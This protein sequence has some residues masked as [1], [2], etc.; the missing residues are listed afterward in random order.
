M[1]LGI[2]GISVAGILI[3]AIFLASKL[4]DN[5]RYLNEKSLEWNKLVKTK[6]LKALST[7]KKMSIDKQL[8]KHLEWDMPHSTKQLLKNYLDAGELS[9]IIIL[10][11]NCDILIS[12]GVRK[13]N[14][15]PCQSSYDFD[16]IDP[17]KSYA[18]KENLWLIQASMN[19]NSNNQQ[20]IIIGSTILDIN[21]QYPTLSS[22]A[23]FQDKSIVPYLKNNVARKVDQGLVLH[24]AKILSILIF[25][26]IA[27]ISLNEMILSRKNGLIL[28]SLFKLLNKDQGNFNEIET[29]VN[30][31]LKES[32][33]ISS[34]N[35]ALKVKLKKLD[36]DHVNQSKKVDRLAFYEIFLEAQTQTRSAL[37]K[38]IQQAMIS[39]SLSKNIYRD[40]K[41]ESFLASLQLSL[42]SL[43]LSLALDE[44]PILQSQSLTKLLHQNVEFENKLTEEVNFPTDTDKTLIS[45]AFFFLYQS[46]MNANVYE[47]VSI[48]AISRK[49][50]GLNHIIIHYS[51]RE[52]N[53]INDHDTIIKKA[54]T[55]FKL[56]GVQMLNLPSQHSRKGLLL[57]WS[58]V[59]KNHSFVQPINRLTNQNR[60]SPQVNL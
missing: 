15:K 10:N 21:H 18:F 60:P 45:T 11:K 22:I 54:E 5:N 56:A 6:E 33:K 34:E 2:L 59:D 3:T 43:K 29:E 42:K 48:Q 12:V 13:E 24:L 53:Q 1:K 28:K 58:T 40:H 35:E 30:Y 19:I 4:Y 27:L 23:D 52:E 46:I 37:K 55:C 36:S 8:F 20:M 51:C 38:K 14:P 47:K 49:T 32:K 41:T 7:L 44:N 16:S 17:L 31:L 39:I 25:I 50:E 26:T 9:S 57:K